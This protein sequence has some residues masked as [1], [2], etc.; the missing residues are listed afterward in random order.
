MFVNATAAAAGTIGLPG[1]VEVDRIIF[2]V[3]VISYPFLVMIGTRIISLE[4]YT[5]F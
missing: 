1:Y 3:I 2:E 5:A 4:L